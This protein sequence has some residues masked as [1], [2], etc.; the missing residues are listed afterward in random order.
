MEVLIP[1][2]RSKKVSGSQGNRRRAVVR[3]P[4]RR[5][6]LVTAEAADGHLPKRRSSL[7]DQVGLWDGAI[8]VAERPLTSPFTLLDSALLDPFHTT[9]VRLDW[10]RTLLFVFCGLCSCS[11]QKHWTDHVVCS[12]ITPQLQLTTQGQQRY[13][14]WFIT[15]ALQH[16]LAFCALLCRAAAEISCDGGKYL[17]SLHT[18]EIDLNACKPR[19]LVDSMDE[20]RREFHELLDKSMVDSNGHNFTPEVLSAIGMFVRAEVCTTSCTFHPFC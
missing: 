2:D 16:E 1:R 10:N 15:C 8:A 18:F 7:D 17:R 6:T 14:N 13:N 20:L 4:H 19:R 3:K 5:F 12:T 9:A 11:P